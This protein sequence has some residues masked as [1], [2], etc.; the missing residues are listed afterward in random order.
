[1][2]DFI[3]G[4]FLAQRGVV[5]MQALL[6]ELW[7]AGIDLELTPEG[8]IA[9]PAGVLS[10][11]QRQAI[12]AHKPQL[13]E[14]LQQTQIKA[15]AAIVDFFHINASWRPFAQA[16]Q[17]HANTCPHC[18]AAGQG[19]GQRCSAGMQ[20]WQNYENRQINY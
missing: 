9:V 19:Y 18:A 1:M 20:L 10:D 3:Y 6:Q 8:G 15:E 12:R 5:M 13:V 11:A 2:Q 16:Y 7:S 17:Q 14:L 4:S